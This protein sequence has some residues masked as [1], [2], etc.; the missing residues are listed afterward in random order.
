MRRQHL[1]PVR[2]LTTELVARSLRHP[3][4]LT[5]ALFL[6]VAGSALPAQGSTAPVGRAHRPVPVLTARTSAAPPVALLPPPG[7]TNFAESP[8]TTSTTSAPSTTSTTATTVAS[9]PP[10][11]SPAQR[12]VNEAHTYVGT[13]YQSGGAS[14]S[15]IDCSG[16]TMMAWRA[17]GVV[18]PHSSSGQYE[19]V[20]H[21]P[22]SQL[23][24][25]D[26]VFYYRGPG[27][28]A[29]YIGNGEV[30]EALT[31]GTRAGVYSI[32][33]AGDPTGAG[34]P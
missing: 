34:R 14:H 6:G 11:P 18:L 23:Q 26:L 7:P 19:D 33:Y 16:L 4:I 31:Y 22:L 29:I 15:G 27:H 8:T 20:R 32:D 30:I 5:G 3:V 21:V 24:P 17:G 28:V 25:G 2:R 10:D 12:A 13:P 1:L 9:P